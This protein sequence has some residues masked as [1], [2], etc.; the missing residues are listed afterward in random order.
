MRDERTNADDRV[1]DVLRELIADRLPDLYLGLADEIVGELVP[2]R[3][4]AVS[5]SVASASSRATRS[6]RE[7][8]RVKS[9]R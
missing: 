8:A 4:N 7:R 1:V 5:K 6:A 9:K 3:M 2:G